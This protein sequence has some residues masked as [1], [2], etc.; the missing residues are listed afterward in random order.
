MYKRQEVYPIW[1]WYGQTEV[2]GLSIRDPGAWGN[3]VGL[4]E[5]T[6][7]NLHLTHGGLS[8]YLQIRKKYFSPWQRAGATTSLGTLHDSK[9]LTGRLILSRLV[10]LLGRLLQRVLKGSLSFGCESCVLDGLIRRQ[11]K[12]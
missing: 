5:L 9:C 4:L 3:V 12:R 11:Y 1:E 7:S 6:L 10:G 8:P 2:L